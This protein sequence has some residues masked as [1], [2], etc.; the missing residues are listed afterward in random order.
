MCEE[1]FGGDLDV[2]E[3]TP[4]P[5]ESD[6][7]QVRQYRDWLHER[8]ERQLETSQKV[9]TALEKMDSIQEARKQLGVLR[10]DIEDT[11]RLRRRS[12][13][14]RGRKPPTKKRS[15]WRSLTGRTSERL[16]RKRRSSI[17]R[18]RNFAV[19]AQK[20]CSLNQ[21]RE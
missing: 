6:K 10:Y 2:T 7:S 16:K 18:R 15:G 12:R 19:R 13:R 20:R 9:E 11:V 14:R 3:M 17:E 5:F 4:D 21:L 8:N 1:L